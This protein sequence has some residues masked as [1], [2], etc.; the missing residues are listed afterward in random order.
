MSP[1]ATTAASGA[2]L[3]DDALWRATAETVAARGYRATSVAHILASAGIARSTFYA[4]YPS[5]EECFS[6]AV[7]E[8][9]RETLDTVRGAVP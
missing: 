1:R 3:P 4:R 2:R 8:I 5:K 6:D 7:E 9:M